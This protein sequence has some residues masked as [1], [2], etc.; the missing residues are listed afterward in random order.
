MP[1]YFFY[2]DKITLIYALLIPL[3]AACTSM[4]QKQEVLNSDKFI[5]QQ[6]F[7]NASSPIYRAS[8]TDSNTAQ[9]FDLTLTIAEGRYSDYEAKKMKNF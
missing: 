4:P 1:N 7:V 3:L 9:V 5:N 8:I 6:I 2:F